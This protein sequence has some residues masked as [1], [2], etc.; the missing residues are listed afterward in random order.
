MNFHISNVLHQIPFGFI[1]PS[2]LRHKLA[3]GIRTVIKPS[4]KFISKYGATNLGITIVL[5]RRT[6]ELEIKGPESDEELVEYFLWLP[7]KKIKNAD[8]YRIAYLNFL[9]EGIL[10]ILGK[11]KFDVKLIQSIFSRMRDNEK[12]IRY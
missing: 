2:D 7:Y 5:E 6:K 8:N 4:Q 11:Y 3:D 12:S 10:K 9:E 1:D